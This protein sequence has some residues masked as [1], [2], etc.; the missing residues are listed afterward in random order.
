MLEYDDH[1]SGTFDVLKEVPKDKTVVLGLVTT[2]EPGT[3]AIVELT[4][5]I[6]EA[7]QHFP[8][9]QLALSPQCGFGTS[10]IGNSLSLSDQIEKLQAVVQTAEAVW[11]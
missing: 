3:E 6:K 1:R 11:A 2:K 8:I 9:E 4:S 5:R 7:S 10:V